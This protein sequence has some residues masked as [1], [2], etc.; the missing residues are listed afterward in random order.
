MKLN[1][2]TCTLAI[3]FSI[4]AFPALAA[5]QQERIYG[6]QLMTQQERIEYRAKIRAAKTVQEREQ[7]RIEHH[8]RMQER[9]KEQGKMLPDNPPERGKGMSP[10]NGMG[11][12]VGRGR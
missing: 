7:I 1:L 8:N 11:Q 5:D 9:A 6:S 3:A 4:T 2:K 10:G 12:G